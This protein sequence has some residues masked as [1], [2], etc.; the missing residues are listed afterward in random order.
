MEN[1]PT[2]RSSCAAL[3]A[4]VAM[5]ALVAGCAGLSASSPALGP[6]ASAL[7]PPNELSGTWHGLFWQVAASL[8][9][10]ESRSVLRMKE[11]GT[12][13]ATF[14]PNG[15]ANNLARPSTWSGTVVRAGNRV[16]FQNSEGCWGRLT[17]ILSGNTLYG[18]A[19]DPM[20]EANVMMRFER[21][22]S[23]G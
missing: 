1:H 10:D 20:T 18:L 3:L 14:T 12:F 23:R 7:A 21:K 11:D 2:Q 5:L 16:T 13:R 17:L 4:A 8:Y 9:E 22:G 19:N 6:V 15:G